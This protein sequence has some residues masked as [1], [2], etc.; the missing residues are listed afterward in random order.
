MMSE[1]FLL[2]ELQDPFF[3][4]LDSLFLICEFC[5]PRAKTSNTENSGCYRILPFCKVISSWTAASCNF[6]FFN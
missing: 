2:L 3:F 1:D 6:F 5:C 4:F